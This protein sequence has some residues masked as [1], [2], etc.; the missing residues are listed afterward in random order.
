MHRTEVTVV[1]E[2]GT[3]G[4][5][6]N[7]CRGLRWPASENPQN[8]ESVD[9]FTISG[10]EAVSKSNPQ[11]LTRFPPLWP[12]CDAFPSSRSSR[13][14]Q[15]TEGQELRIKAFFPTWKTPPSPTQFPT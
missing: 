12:L 15:R 14:M 5:A 7:F 6:G 4:C 11:C 10:P 9:D 8:W 1:T 3:W 13:T 2:G